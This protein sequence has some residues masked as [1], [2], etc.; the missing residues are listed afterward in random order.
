MDGPATAI[1]VDREAMDVL[2]IAGEK[3]TKYRVHR[4]MNDAILRTAD[5]LKLAAAT[6]SVLVSGSPTFCAL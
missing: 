3:L 5:F 2:L 6:A 4:K 1:G